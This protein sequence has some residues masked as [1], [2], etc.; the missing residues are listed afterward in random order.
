M[1][2]SFLFFTAFTLTLA[3]AK[4][5]PLSDSGD[6]GGWTLIESVSDEFNSNSLDRS[7]W[8]NLG[9]DGNYH[10]EW[11]GRAPSQYDPANITVKDGFLSIASKWNPDFKF[12]DSLFNGTSY[13]KPAPVT[14]AAIITK[15]KFKYGYLEMRC[16]AADGPVSSSFWTTGKDGEIDVFEH[17]GDNPGN[18]NSAHRYHTSF[19]DWRKGSPTF[20]KRIWENDHR[21][22]FKVAENFHVYGLD[23]TPDRLGIYLD[24]RLIR[25]VTKQELG[26]KWIATNEQKIWIDSETFDWEIK[27]D[28][29]KEV[30]F[31]R[32]P[33][34][35]VDYCRVW[36]RSK[37]AVAPKLPPNMFGNQGFEE[38]LKYWVGEGE[39]TKDGFLGDFAAKL[40]KSGKIQQ[41]VNVK[42]NTTYILSAWAKLPGTNMKDAWTDAYL[43]VASYGGPRLGVKLFKPEFHRKSLEF[44]TGP[45]AKKATIWITNQPKNNPVIVDHFELIE[46]SP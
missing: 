44:T 4:P 41:T 2:N 33:E 5:L 34:F 28:Q 21:L 35:I 14:T 37:P 9:Q 32:N 27:P 46:S 12:S 38:G 11:K 42:P 30:A 40:G 26:D 10:G 22:G 6:S 1:T 17:F 39:I 24:G 7:K 15:A 20:G 3:C 31:A 19:H 45:E 43:N 23:W 25:T 8:I 18:P 16:K 36:Q 29:L 13:G